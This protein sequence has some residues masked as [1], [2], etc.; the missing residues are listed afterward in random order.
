MLG[1]EQKQLDQLRLVQA[2]Y[3]PRIKA[4][5]K[6]LRKL[7]A[8]EAAELAKVLTRAQRDKLR[9][10]QKRAGDQPKS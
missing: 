2:R 3:E 8:E 1:V 5:D 4:L 6:E 9:E 10:I 7:R